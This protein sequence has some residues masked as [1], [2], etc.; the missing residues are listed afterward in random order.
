MKLDT[1][2]FNQQNIQRQLI[3]VPTSVAIGP[4]LFK[5]AESVSF[6]NYCM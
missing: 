1:I 5:A 6:R 4:F 2:Y 3:Q